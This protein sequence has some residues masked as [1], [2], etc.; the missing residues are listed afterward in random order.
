MAE[1]RGFRAGVTM[2]N[3]VVALDADLMH[4]QRFEPSCFAGLRQAQAAARERAAGAVAQREFEAVVRQW[5]AVRR[6]W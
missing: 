4:L 5:R 3:L 2:S 1:A 6:P